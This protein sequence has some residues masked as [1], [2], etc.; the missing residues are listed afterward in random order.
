[1]T[2]RDVIPI[3]GAGGGGG[4]KGGGG[5]SGSR[6]PQESPDSL[7]SIQYARVINLICEGTV[8]GI[9]NWARGIYIE[10]TPLQNPDGSWNFVGAAFEYRGGEPDQPPM[11]GFPA[12]ESET[13]VGVTVTINGPVVRGVVNP[14]IDAVRVTVGVPSLSSTDVGTGDVDGATI[15]LAVD[16]QKDGGGFQQMLVDTIAGKT[17]SRYQRSYYINLGRFGPPGGSYD[18][19][20]R[21]ITPDSTTVYLVNAF[22]WETMTEIVNSN[23]MYPNSALVG[24]QVDASTFRQIPKLAFDIR[25]RMVQV[26][27]NYDP[28][29]RTYYGVWDGTFRVAWTDNPAWVLYDLIVTPRFGLGHYVNPDMVDKWNLYAIAQYCDALVPDGFGGWEPR[30]TCNIYIQTREEAISLLQQLA[31]IFNGMIFWTGGMLTVIADMPG[32]PVTTFTAANVVDGRITYRGTPLNQRHTVALVTWSNPANRYEQDIEYVEDRDAVNTWGVRELQVTALGCTSRGQAHRVG[33]WMLLTEQML[34]E[35][36]SFKTGINGAFLKPGDLFWTSD[37]VRTGYRSG[38]RVIEAT[39]DALRLDQAI[40]FTPGVQ[41]SINVILPDGSVQGSVL[42]ATGTTDAIRL[43]TPLRAAPLRMAVWTISATNAADEWWRCISVVEEEEGTLEV[44]GVAYR[45]EKFAAIEQGIRLE[46]LPRGIIDPFNVGR[47]TEL[48]VLESVYQISPV[49]VSARAT[50]SW[51]APVGAVR[52]EIS[53]QRQDES[54]TFTESFMSS[55]DIQPTREGTWFFNV[56][57]VNSI[58]V[59]GPIA[60]IEVE[61]VALNRPPQ[62]VQEFQLDIYNDAA[63]LRWRP[64]EALDVIVGGQMIV[65]Y[66]SRMSTEVTWE[67]AQEIIRFTGAQSSGFSPLMKGAYLAKFVNSSGRFSIGT[68][69]IISTTGPLR[70][71]NVVARLDQQPEFPGVHVNTEVFTGVLY[72]ALAPD[73]LLEATEATYYLAPEPAVDMGMVYT[74]RCQAVIEGAVFGLNDSVD[75]W[76]DWDLRLDVDGMKVDEGGAQV[77]QRM[78]NV[79]P[80]IAEPED[81]SPWR[82]LV[83]AD[84]TFRAIEFAAIMRT[85][86]RTWGMGITDLSVEVDVPDRIESRNNVPVPATGVHIEYTVPFM[87]APAIAII[88]QDLQSGDRWA[89]TNQSERGFSIYFTNSA[90]VW[91]EKTC[92]WIARGYGYEH[93]VLA[94]VGYSKMMG[95]TP[96]LAAQRAAIHKP[97]EE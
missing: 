3:T 12:S 39:N 49:V 9:V 79:H 71:Y 72:M 65:R 26:P 95:V 44:Q 8:S 38:G 40:A 91:I 76:P 27:T 63:N 75:L 60:S 7:R 29:T 92:D 13:S 31:S 84:L 56:A 37:P 83:V 43:I 80:A 24:V 47:C 35:T 52:F 55:I 53:Y 69:Y 2:S 36:V 74:V 85:T 86:D 96:D 50:F 28:E 15:Q 20:V 68:A 70:D 51:L 33:R 89:I 73:G 14:N 81:W 6:S 54:P 11:S 90:G 58:G 42:S 10:D 41:Y 23:L 34:S 87:E 16:V 62:D 17:T 45:Q 88:A 77:V 4:G 21:R 93:T 94:G 5:G 78:T 61:I 25:M 19:R 64:A 82:R 48:R 67:E 1:M 57:A 59:R 22:Q 46:P 18:V 30:Y 97:A 32:D 66:S